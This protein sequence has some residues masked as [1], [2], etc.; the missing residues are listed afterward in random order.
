M[1]QAQSVG[2]RLL[3]ARRALGMSRRAVEDASGVSARALE[4]LEAGRQ[5]VSLSRAVALCR[6]YGLSL[7]ELVGEDAGVPAGYGADR[8]P[9]VQAVHGLLGKLARVLTGETTSLDF[10][11]DQ[12]RGWPGDED[13]DQAEVLSRVEVVLQLFD[14]LD[15]VV[16]SR[17]QPRRLPAI[18]H[19]LMRDGAALDADELYEVAVKRG[20]GLTDGLVG[21]AAVQLLIAD[22]FYDGITRLSSEELDELADR[23][24]AAAGIKRGRPFFGG[25]EVLADRP[26]HLL[27]AVQDSAEKRRKTLLRQLPPLIVSLALRR[28]VPV[29]KA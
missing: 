13:E 22:T 7:T 14:Q 15:Q 20:L 26:S 28:S 3:A 21:E 12:G 24:A 8:S 2:A 16:A 29:A 6:L 18:V 23:L 1:V 10:D 4:K 27:L 17:Q 25:Q 19:D 11:L 5:E 9:K